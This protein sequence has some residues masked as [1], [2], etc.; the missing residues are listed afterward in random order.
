MTFRDVIMLPCNLDALPVVQTHS[1]MNKLE[2][3]HYDLYNKYLLSIC[4]W[5]HSNPHIVQVIDNLSCFC[6][7]W[8]SSI[9][10]DGQ[11]AVIASDQDGQDVVISTQDDNEPSRPVPKIQRTLGTP[12]TELLYTDGTSKGSRPTNSG[13]AITSSS[14][15]QP[16]LHKFINLVKSGYNIPW[17]FTIS[18]L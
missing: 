1:K 9:S 8:G 5:T 4:K 11:A 2:G 3:H 7:K 14:K 15:D 10:Q 17:I 6:N 18:I 16:I 12:W 13:V